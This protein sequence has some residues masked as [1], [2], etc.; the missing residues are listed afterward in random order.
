MMPAGV[1]LSMVL[2][3][4]VPMCIVTVLLRALPFHVIKYVKGNQLVGLL[5]HLMPVGVMTVL[6]VYTLHGQADAPGG[7]LA[8]ALGVAATL[9]IHVWRRNSGLS[10][11][12][13]TAF[14]MVLVNFMW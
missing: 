5:G 14:Y 3:V 6:L 11:F 12:A 1:S 2:A 13:G 9:A 8:A 10:I 7:L 4:L